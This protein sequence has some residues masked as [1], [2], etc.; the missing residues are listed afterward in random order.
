M[1]WP[2]SWLPQVDDRLAVRLWASKPSEGTGER[3]ICPRRGWMFILFDYYVRM[4]GNHVSTLILIYI[5]CPGVP[6]N[7]G[8]F[9]QVDEAMTCWLQAIQSLPPS[10]PKGLLGL[11]PGMNLGWRMLKVPSLPTAQDFSITNEVLAGSNGFFSEFFPWF[12][13]LH[14]PLICVCNEHLLIWQ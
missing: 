7:L 3:Q 6:Q 9:F 11:I 4:L 12:F 10:A 1:G 13:R 2:T 5:I 8:I 14:W